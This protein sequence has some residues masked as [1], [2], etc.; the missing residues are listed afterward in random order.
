MFSK[1]VY[2]KSDAEHCQPNGPNARDTVRQYFRPLLIAPLGSEY[3]HR[4]SLEHLRVKYA[5]ILLIYRSMSVTNRISRSHASLRRHHQYLPIFNILGIYTA[6]LFTGSYG[7][8]EAQ[9][10]ISWGSSASR[11]PNVECIVHPPIVTGHEMT[12]YLGLSTS[13]YCLV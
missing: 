8:H 2:S 13:P 10:M 5:Q 4:I 9:P 1:A 7:M 3:Q 11:L 6:E 12:L